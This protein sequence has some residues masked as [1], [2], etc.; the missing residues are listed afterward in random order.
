M[1]FEKQGL[2][3]QAEHGKVC[4]RNFTKEVF[5]TDAVLFMVPGSHAVAYISPRH[6]IIPRAVAGCDPYPC[7]IYKYSNLA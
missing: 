4:F 5:V 7:E 6:C 1:W 2:G 3:E